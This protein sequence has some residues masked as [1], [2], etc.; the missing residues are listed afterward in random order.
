MDEAI[1][2]LPRTHHRLAIFKHRVITQAKLNKPIQFDMGKFRD[3]SESLLAQMWHRVAKNSKNKA[4]QLSAHLNSIDVLTTDEHVFQKVE[5]LAEFSEWLFVNEYPR[6]KAIDH[7]SYAIC[8][9][10]KH[11]VSVKQENTQEET[12]QLFGTLVVLYNTLPL[13]SILSI[14]VNMDLL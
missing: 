13:Y 3:E 10:T 6:Q 5:Y 1:K 2:V 8:L 11:S 7:L 9:L 14:R 4:D 12:N